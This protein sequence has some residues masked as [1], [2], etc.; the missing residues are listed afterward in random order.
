MSLEEWMNSCDLFRMYKY[1]L[2]NRLKL[3]KN[4]ELSR[5]TKQEMLKIE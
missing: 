1:Q 2:D 4:E 5:N 3:V